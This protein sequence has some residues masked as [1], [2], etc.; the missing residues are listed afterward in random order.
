LVR[1]GEIVTLEGT[2]RSE[3]NK[4]YLDTGDESYLIRFRE[5]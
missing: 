5:K 2:L 4:W 3:D 1:I